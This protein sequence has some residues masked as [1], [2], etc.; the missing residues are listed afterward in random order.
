[1]IHPIRCLNERRPGTDGGIS[2]TYT[3]RRRVK[4]DLL[5]HSPAANLDH[6]RDKPVHRDGNE[7]HR[8]VIDVELGIHF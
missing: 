8:R 1:M 2:D 4:L 7:L 5:F 3:V 6:V